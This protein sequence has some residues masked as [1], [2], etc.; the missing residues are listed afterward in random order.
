MASPKVYHAE[1][2]AILFDHQSPILDGTLKAAQSYVD[3]ITRSVWWKTHCEESWLGDRSGGHEGECLVPK[4][5][6]VKEGPATMMGESN[7][8]E[9]MIY[10]GKYYPHIWLGRL[11]TT[12]DVESIAD[13]WVIIHEVAHV[14]AACADHIGHGREFQ[15]CLYD[16]VKKYL[17][18]MQA[19]LLYHGYKSQGLTVWKVL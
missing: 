2:F 6:I 4:R 16:L 19:E 9:T 1:E 18:P 14:M 15:L 11:P 10:R 3:S 17:G 5:I 13:P 7:L 12:R 8:I